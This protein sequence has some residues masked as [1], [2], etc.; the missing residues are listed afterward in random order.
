[1]FLYTPIRDL[2][3]SSKTVALLHCFVQVPFLCRRTGMV[4]GVEPVGAVALEDQVRFGVQ[5]SVLFG[6]AE[7]GNGNADGN[8]DASD[9]NA[10]A[11]QG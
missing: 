5:E 2:L 9:G 8:G 4:T 6:S 11:N 1:M 10:P 7:N 3:F